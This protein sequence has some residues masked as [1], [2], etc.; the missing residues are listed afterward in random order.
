MWGNYL[1]IAIRN[2][3]KQKGYSLLNITG[4]AIGMGVCILIL[5]FVQNEISYDKQN[6]YADNVVRIEKNF[7]RSGGNVTQGFCSLAP[8]FA[9]LLKDNIPEFEHLARIYRN[10]NCLIE[11]GDRKILQD[12][13]H[14]AEADIF[15]ILD[16]TLSQ[17]DKTTAL[18][19]PATAV[20]TP[21]TAKKIFGNEN[22]IG[23]EFVFEREHTIRVTGIMEP[24]P[25]NSHIHVDMFVS[26]KTLT[27][28]GEQTTDYFLGDNN[29][30]DNVTLIYARF[31]KG[32]T[33][34]FLHSQIANVLNNRFET[35][36]L[37]NG[38][39][40]N[41]NDY[42]KLGL[43]PIKR[44]HLYSKSM[45]EIEPSG[46]IKT[47]IIFTSIAIFILLIACI[48]FINLSTA[49]ATSRAKEVG[50]R[51]VIGANRKTLAIQFFMESL[52]IALISL[53]IA[54]VGVM[55]LLPTYSTFIG[56]N[57]SLFGNHQ[58]S[59]ILIGIFIFAGL[60]SGLYPALYLS[61]YTPSTILRGEISKGKKGATL[62]K[63]LVIFQFI[64]TV[65]LIISV[66]VVSRQ[67]NFLNNAKLGFDKEN[68]ILFPS[69]Q[70]MRDQWQSVKNRLLANPNVLSVTGSKRI[71][72]GRLMDS[73]GFQV[74][75]N[76]ELVNS[77]ISLQNQRVDFGFLDTYGIEL[78]C[79]RDLD[80][81][82]ATD[83][84]S[85]VLLNE[86]AVRRLGWEKPEDALG[87][88][89]TSGN[90]PSTIVGVIKDFHF[91]SLHNQITPM[92]IH[93][94]PHFR[95]AAVRIAPGDIPAT[96]AHI[97]QVWDEVHPGL[98]FDF[99]FLDERFDKL[100]KNENKMLQMFGWFSL[101]AILVA[102]L[103]LVGL[104]SFM[105]EKRTKEIGIRKTLGATIG[106]VVKLLTSDFAKL[107]LFGIVLA[108]P[109]GWYSMSKWLD[110]FAYRINISVYDIILAAIVALMIT[111]ISVIYQAL[112]AASSNPVKAL[113]SE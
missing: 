101:L 91:E 45:N 92:L 62:R 103:G 86:T 59:L 41:P 105:A 34:D 42:I 87:V 109:I 75:V 64:I 80:P 11:N 25:E 69:E 6:S 19:E 71:P 61:S 106:N 32:T 33:L 37:N 14:M 40:Q 3:V 89:I 79:G 22:P 44:I 47:V 67:M 68:V 72:S 21:A 16:I 53:M 52:S 39:V 108:I 50:L 10:S 83:S 38:G 12:E 82:I 88:E 7:V 73:P 77:G 81:N 111:F 5:L 113:R 28:Y 8:S 112:K 70:P 96:V 84:S 85:A 13:V 27:L 93:I 100:Y 58:I 20:L 24:I 98:P 78:V 2:L 36:E 43:M 107:A 99:F 23:K 31:T 102:C 46:D 90:R 66:N 29:F 65:T 60:L 54:V 9:P 56:V 57:L 48:N 63:V 1:K 95:Y 17:G 49:R 26:Y 76:G 110:N 30:S 18:L 55:L 4:L 94:I 74:E 15:D 104:A 97:Q 35:Q 51:K